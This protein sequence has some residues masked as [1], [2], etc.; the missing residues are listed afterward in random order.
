MSKQNEYKP[1]Y[2]VS[3]GEVVRDYLEEFDGGFNP[4]GIEPEIEYA[5]LYSHTKDQL[6]L[7]D[8]T[9]KGLLIGTQPITPAI[10]ARLEKLGRPAHF[11]LNLER[12]YQEDR[13]R[14]SE[15]S[16]WRKVEDE[17]PPKDGSR[18]L[19]RCVPQGIMFVARYSSLLE[20]YVDDID[21]AFA[22]IT[23][24]TEWMPIPGGGE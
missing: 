22:G 11:W 21:G 4:Q 19:V 20:D 16:P 5:L 8:D 2:L 15:I 1:D 10:A 18:F 6:D 14:L 9:V 13:A 17:P 12:Q 7:D 23:V 24:T 3:P